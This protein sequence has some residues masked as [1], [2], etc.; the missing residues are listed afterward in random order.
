MIAMIPIACICVMME[1]FEAGQ[2][3]ISKQ[4]IVTQNDD[5][6]RHYALGLFLGSSPEEVTISL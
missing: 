3:R 5:V 6:G 1:D 4:Q 2:K